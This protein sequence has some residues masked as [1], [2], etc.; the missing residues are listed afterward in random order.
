MLRYRLWK[1]WVTVGF[2]VALAVAPFGYP[3][4]ARVAFGCG[5]A[6]ELLLVLWWRQ[7]IARARQARSAPK[8]QPHTP[9][10]A[11]EPPV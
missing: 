3:L 5:A 7:I 11:G 2:F 10:A 9:S 8:A 6:V 4:A 1:L